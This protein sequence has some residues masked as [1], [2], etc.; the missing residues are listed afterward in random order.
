MLLSE[1]LDSED[2][3]CQGYWAKDANNIYV[4]TLDSKACRWC[5]GGAMYK[6]SR[7]DK[8]FDYEDVKSKVSK[9]VGGNIP[10]WNDAIE[11]TFEDV[12]TMMNAL[13]I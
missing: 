3:W 11:R 7:L 4:D 8:T 6:V 1:F 13:G 10:L 12:K 9:Y 2:K 5:L